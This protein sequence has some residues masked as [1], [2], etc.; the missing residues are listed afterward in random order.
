MK[1]IRVETHDNITDESGAGY[2]SAIHII[3][4]IR[5]GVEPPETAEELATLINESDDPEIKK[6]VPIFYMLCD[7][8]QPEVYIQDKQNRV[9][10]YQLEEF[11]EC[12]GELAYISRML[13]DVTDNRMLLVYKEFELEDNELLYED[14]YQVVISRET[15][16]KHE[17][18]LQYDVMLGFDG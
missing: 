6:M 10:L 11:E 5:L 12:Y 1:Y 7:I 8:P 14:A 16:N 17:E 15:Y 18:G 9:C 13:F 2:V 4:A 3:L